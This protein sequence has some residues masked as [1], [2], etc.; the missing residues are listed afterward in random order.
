MS[1]SP[2]EILSW[3]NQDLI[4]NDSDFYEEDQLLEAERAQETIVLI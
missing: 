2:W 3:Q 4:L 1:E